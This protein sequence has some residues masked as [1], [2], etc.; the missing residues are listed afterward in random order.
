MFADQ[1]EI[2]D[3]IAAIWGIEPEY[4]DIWG[5]RHPTSRKTKLAILRAWA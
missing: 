3:K 5:K 2:I 4:T 1:G